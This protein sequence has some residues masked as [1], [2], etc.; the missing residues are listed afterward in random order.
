VKQWCAVLL[1]FISL[2]GRAAEVIP[3]KPALYFNDY[4]HVVSA[5][6]ASQLNE[7][8]AEFER[9][10]SDQILVAVFPRMQSD[11]SI[12]DYT[13]RVARSWDVGQKG[14]NNGA[15]LFVFVENR[16]AYIQ[17][18][19]G[20]EGALPDVIAKRIIENEL[21]PRFRN[22]D[23]DGGLRA[24]VAAIIAAVNGE[25]KGSGSTVAERGRTNG[26]NP[27]WLVVF[28]I[29]LFGIIGR[30]FGRSPRRRGYWGGVGTAGWMINS[31]GYWGGGGRSSGGSFGGGSSGFSGGG[32]DFGGGGAGGSW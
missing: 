31:G 5:A 4:A 14:K 24:S 8:L 1:L 2:V 3:A 9:Q 22:G 10:S 28:F 27:F 16:K 19:Y 11:S 32:G 6:T 30:L 7:T 12:E 21:T 23:Y 20:L 17:V 25:Y 26:F 29:V 13:V 15:V 18:G